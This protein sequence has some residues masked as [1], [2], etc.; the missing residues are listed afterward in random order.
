LLSRVDRGDRQELSDQLG[1]EQGLP[2]GVD[3]ELPL[4]IPTE[5]IDLARVPPDYGMIVPACSL[6]YELVLQ[7]FND[8]GCIAGAGVIVSE[9]PIVIEP[10]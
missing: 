9:L 3:P 6:C 10:A 4:V 7:A 8:Y 1:C 5:S 2:V